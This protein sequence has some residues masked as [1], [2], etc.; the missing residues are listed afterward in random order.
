MIVDFSEKLLQ[1]IIEWDK[2]LHMKGFQI[3]IHEP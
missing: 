2:D 3:S 1:V